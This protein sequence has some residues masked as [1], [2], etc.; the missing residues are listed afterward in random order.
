M[1]QN[2]KPEDDAPNPVPALIG[3]ALAVIASIPIAAFVAARIGGDYDTRAMI[4]SGFVLWSVA[5]AVI[6][7]MRTHRAERGGVSVGRVLKW[8]ASIWLW[9]LIALA[10]GRKA[11]PPGE[12]QQP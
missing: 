3:A 12:D 5:G 2:R 7:F 8:M 11:E 10:P 1:S 4:Y 6:V 9:P